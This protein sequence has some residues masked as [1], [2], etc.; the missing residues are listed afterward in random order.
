MGLEGRMIRGAAAVALAALL[1]IGVLLALPAGAWDARPQ[2][3]SSS[4]RPAV[5][6]N[7]V[8]WGGT[9][10]DAYDE[11]IELYNTT[12]AAVDL[13]GWT[14]VAFDGTP[15]IALSGVIPPHATFLLEHGVDDAAISD[16]P[17][18]Q[19]YGVYV[20]AME[21]GGEVLELW[22]PAGLLVDSA[23][24]DGGGWPAG[25]ASEDYFSMERIDPYAAD[26]DDNWAANDGVIR[27]G[28][29]AEG[30]PINGTPKAWNS[31]G[32]TADLGVS[33]I[34]PAVVWPGDE[35][36]YTL[37]VSNSGALTATAVTLTDTLPAGVVYLRSAAPYPLSRPDDR[38]LVWELGTLPANSGATSFSF[39]GQLT[40]PLLGAITNTF[41]G[42]TEAIERH[43]VDNRADWGSWVDSS[44]YYADLVVKKSGPTHVS[45]GAA[46][47]YTLSLSNSGG[48]TATRVVLTD[49]LPAG[50]TFAFQD[51]SLIHI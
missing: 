32:V 40:V 12:D 35:I 4:V 1:L 3:S 21:D 27:N 16:I 44:T 11:W 17:A 8:A 43:L 25:T 9:D 30:E 41:R 28:I 2:N 33:K 42:G 31:A 50:V 7:E 6:I 24:G 45:A 20:N 14:L 48:L 13:D 38:T 19:V 5:V 46:I 10:A 47:S 36:T 49:A 34:G 51:L 22:N 18:D 26:S 39:T 15:A 23:N 37:T 29:D